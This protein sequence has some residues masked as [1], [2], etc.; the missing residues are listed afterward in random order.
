MCSNETLPPVLMVHG[1]KIN[2]YND[3]SYFIETRSSRRPND[4]VKRDNYPRASLEVKKYPQRCHQAPCL[5][6]A[7]VSGRFTLA[8]F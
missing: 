3:G 6:C 8:I 4:W 1:Q 2:S 7:S 5:L